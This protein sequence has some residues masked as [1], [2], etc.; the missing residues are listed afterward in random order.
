MCADCAPGYAYTGANSGVCATCTDNP[1]YYVVS[2]LLGVVGIAYI[3]FMIKQALK[4]EKKDKEKKEDGDKKEVE[5]K[6]VEG[7]I[8]QDAEEEK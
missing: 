8:V 2:A 1:R 5:G 3:V 4:E 6:V 7:E